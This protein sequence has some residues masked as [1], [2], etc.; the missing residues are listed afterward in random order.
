MKVAVKRVLMYIVGV[1][2]ISGIIGFAVDVVRN[3]FSLTSILTLIGV[4]IVASLWVKDFRNIKWKM[5][6]RGKKQ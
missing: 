2:L 3:D 6:E 4:V 1:L 5:R